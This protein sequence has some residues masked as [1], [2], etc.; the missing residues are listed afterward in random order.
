MNSRVFIMLIIALVFAGGAAWVAYRWVES[1]PGQK[2][3]VSMEVVPV[4]VAAIEIPFGTKIDKSHVKVSNFPKG[5]VPEAAFIDK[6]K[7]IGKIVQRKYI[8]NEVLLEP[9]VKD[10]LGGS[11]LSALITEG[12][13]AV[14]VRVNDV[15]G[16]AGF[17]A[18]GNKVDIIATR[19]K[20]STYP[21]LSNVKVLAIGQLASPDQ[22]KPAVVNSLTLELTPEEAR[23][24]VDAGRKGSLYFTLRNPLDDSQIATSEFIETPTQEIEIIETVDIVEDTVVTPPPVQNTPKKVKK[25][26][27]PSFKMIPWQKRT[28]DEFDE[29]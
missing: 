10:Y 21:L 6:E 23:K 25:P 11:T 17:I 7:V 12:M 2:A 27:G 19:S 18:P 9:Q 24:V 1:Q 5:S 22:A 15:V 4:V 28:E 3:S 16:V 13:R 8:A 29:G 14:S 26:Q 20:G